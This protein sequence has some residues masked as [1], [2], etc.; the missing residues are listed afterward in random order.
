[1]PSPQKARNVKGNSMKYLY[2]TY[3]F[4]IIILSSCAMPEE[5]DRL[6]CS[7][8]SRTIEAEPDAFG[9]TGPIGKDKFFTGKLYT[10]KPGYVFLFR[11]CRAEKWKWE[12]LAGCNNEILSFIDL[13]GCAQW[14]I[15]NSLNDDS[16]ASDPVGPYAIYDGNNVDVLKDLQNISVSLSITVSGTSISINVSGKTSLLD[17]A[18]QNARIIP[19]DERGTVCLSKKTFIFAKSGGSVLSSL[20]YSGIILKLSLTPT[21]NTKNERVY[22]LNYSLLGTGLWSWKQDVDKKHN[23][24]IFLPIRWDTRSGSLGTLTFIKKGE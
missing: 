5:S 20:A 21:P 15:S 7:F 12:D 1:M 13:P 11:D 4:P 3:I 8:E 6:K 9:M 16:I 14:D 18:V 2:F 17:S 19:D 10:G 23:V 24:T 22:A